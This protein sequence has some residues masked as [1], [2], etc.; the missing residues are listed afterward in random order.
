[1][2]PSGSLWRREALSG[3][4]QISE[5]MKQLEHFKGLNKFLLLLYCL[6]HVEVS[7]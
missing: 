7:P 2:E 4:C 6:P 3:D 5:K 1:M